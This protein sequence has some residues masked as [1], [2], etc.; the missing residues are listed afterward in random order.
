MEEE[1]KMEEETFLARTRSGLMQRLTLIGA[2]LNVFLVEQ[3]LIQHAQAEGTTPV[4]QA[5]PT[6]LTPE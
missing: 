3:S 4:N 1:E 5:N 2:S 6:P